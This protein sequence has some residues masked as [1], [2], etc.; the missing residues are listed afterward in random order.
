MKISTIL[1]HID[2]GHIALPTFQRGYVWNRDLVRGLMDSLY[3]SHP[4]GSLLVWVTSTD[5]VHSRGDQ[6]LAPGIVRLL[7]DGQQRITSLYGIIRGVEPAFFDGNARAFTGLH[8][9]IKTE[10]FRFYQQ[11]LMTSD[12]HWIDITK[13]LKDGYTGVGE[14]TTWLSQQPELASELGEYNGRLHKLLGIRDIELHIEEVTGTDKTVEVVVDIFNRVNSGGTKL[15]KGDLALAKICGSWPEGR[16]RMQTVLERWKEN[17]YDFNLDWLLRNMNAIVTGEARFFHLHDIPTSTISDGLDRAEKSIN[18]AL[19]LI[20]DRLGLDHDRVLFGRYALPVMS[21]YIDQRGGRLTDATER[22]RLLC[23]Y[24]QSAMWGRFSG[25]TES[26]LDVDL[27]T[28]EDMDNGIDRLFEQ[29]R[30]WH[31]SLR[32]EPGHFRGWSLGARFYPVL[33]ALTR[34]GDAKDW[35][36]GLA[37]KSSLHGRMSTLEVHHIFPKAHLYGHRPKFR[38]PEVNAIA[39]FCLLTKD[40]NLQISA[41]PPSEYFPE[42]ERK[43]PG[44]LASQWIPMDRELWKTENY[45]QFL[46]ERQRLLATAANELLEGLLHGTSTAKL[47]DTDQIS[48]PE[49]F[50]IPCGIENPAEEEALKSINSWL[51]QLGLPE[52]HMEHE[53][54]HPDT[55]EPLAI[56]DLAWPNGLQEGFSDPVAL[57][58]D[59]EQETL[60]IANDHGFRHFTNTD[61]FKRYVESDV[62]A[63]AL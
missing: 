20:A 53:L 21:R 55:G 39:N 28:I 58:L 62:I 3:R 29:L 4:V 12:P 34:T 19:N 36:T 32:I 37:L 15:S 30:L 1:D 22:D 14:H 24:F 56:L 25:S 50:S 17:G 63:M 9:H 48:V 13:L 52:G 60:Q 46:D 18:Y 49:S 57:L 11:S 54:S 2:S 27:E 41:K 7:L 16:E 42:V 5:G 61:S 40:T 43:H 10:E 51:R 6:E 8:F 59:E 47:L 35:G 45:L 31:G 33:Y 44:A 23:W 26:I 38:K